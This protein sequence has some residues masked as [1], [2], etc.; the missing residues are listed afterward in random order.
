MIDFSSGITDSFVDWLGFIN[1]QGS[2]PIIANLLHANLW[3]YLVSNMELKE[4]F[5]DI[6]YSLFDWLDLMGCDEVD[7]LD[8]KRQ[9][10]FYLGRSDEY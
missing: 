8:F 4:F 5:S 2:D 3:Y 9:F 6:T 10:W 7:L 1:Y